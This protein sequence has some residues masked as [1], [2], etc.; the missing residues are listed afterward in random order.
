MWCRAR[1]DMIPIEVKLAR[2]LIYLLVLV[3]RVYT[4]LLLGPSTLESISD[5]V[6]A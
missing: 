5:S 6:Y 1:D 3:L 2:T 4:L